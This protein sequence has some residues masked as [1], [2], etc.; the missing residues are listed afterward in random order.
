MRNHYESYKAITGKIKEI[1]DKL[2]EYMQEFI[3]REC[4]TEDKDLTDDGLYIDV[5]YQDSSCGC[6]YEEYRKSFKWTLSEFLELSVDELVEIF[7]KKEG[8]K[9]AKEKEAKKKYELE[10]KEAEEKEEKELLK[11]LQDK[12]KNSQ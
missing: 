3:G 7:K 2:K 5:A 9:L 12:Y 4:Y 8:E 1:E 6:C 10:K 11:K